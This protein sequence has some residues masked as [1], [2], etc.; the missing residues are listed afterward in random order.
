MRSPNHLK[1]AA[2]LEHDAADSRHRPMHR[3]KLLQAAERERGLARKQDELDG[4]QRRR[5]YYG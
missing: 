3:Q 1:L 2:Q 4:Q 5:R